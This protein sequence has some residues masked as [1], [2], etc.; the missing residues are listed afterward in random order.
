[1]NYNEALKYALNGEAVFLV[2]SGFS[3]DAENNVNGSDKKL[4]V[5][6]KL[7]KELAELTEMDMDVQLD[8]V[9]QEYIEIYG[10]RN[11][12][13]YL[14]EHYTVEKY[15]DYYKIISEMKNIRMYSTNYDNLIE[16]VCNDCGKKVKGYNIESDIRKAN[17][18]RMVMHLNG[19]IGDL[20]NNELPESFK[21][22]HLSYNN[23]EFFSTPWYSYLVDELHS[24]KVIFIIGLSFNSDLD[25]RR[26]VSSRELKEKIFFI[27]KPDITTA[28]RKF[29]DKYGRVLLCGVQRFFQDLSNVCLEENDEK[30]EFYYK[31]FKRIPRYNN[32]VEAVDENVYE[33]LSKGK[34]VDGLYKKD[35]NRK[36]KTLVN[37]DRVNEVAEGLKEG[38]S[39]IVFSDLG[40]GKSI[41]VNQVIDMCTDMEFY[42]MKQVL[43]SKILAEIRNLCG[44]DNVKI[45]ICDPVNLFLDNL[46]IFSN[47]DL[48]NIRFIF[49]VRSSMYDNY[50]NKIY[51]IIDDMK[52]VQFS[53]PICLDELSENEIADLDRVLS[54]YGFYGDLAGF[55]QQKRYDYL[56]NKC[57][58]KFQSIL[59]YIFES[60]HIIDR[61]VKDIG[62]LKEKGDLRKIL[63]LSFI[64]SILE[65]GLGINDYRM[66]LDVDD[67]EK[68]IKRND[69]CK[70]LLDIERE[71]IAVKSSI[72]AK[73]LMMKTEVFSKNEVFDVLTTV[74]QKLDDLYLGSERYKNAMINLVS[75]SYISYVFGYKMD[76]E[77]LIEYYEKAKELK[78]CKRNLFFW[79]QYAIACVNL[80]QF[81]R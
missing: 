72:V 19:Y 63:I 22:S 73:E 65:L 45:I 37:R 50:Y 81:D 6:S 4:W 80:D 75:C 51:D 74:I 23:N 2:G 68:V 30:K 11:L 24:T 77:K 46:K 59:L 36:Y 56:K 66:L 60:T 39:Y 64:S 27:E 28:C 61:F 55:S 49:V 38:K 48:K 21:L 67:V 34:E 18:D 47:F 42:Y 29:L 20:K 5:G 9:S 71:E 13:S 79:E 53:N 78:F 8:I 76:S 33:L 44:E 31:S 58:S 10:E 16:K 43:N 3:A 25:I 15:A 14:K 69:N 26:I 35:E 54:T 57:K 1:M 32:S 17:K 70:E 40:N 62:N 7:A 12:V 41:F 52:N